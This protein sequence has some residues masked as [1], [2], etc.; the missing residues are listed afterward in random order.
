MEAG[1]KP[2][3]EVLTS[4]RRFLIPEYQRP[5]I[6][7]KEEVEQLWHDL[8]GAF[9][10]VADN[11][12]LLT[13]SEAYFLGPIVVANERDASGAKLSNVVDGQ[14]RLTTLNALLWVIHNCLKAGDAEGT[15]EKAVELERV[16]TL[17]DGRSVLSVAGADQSNFHAIREGTVLD[18]TRELGVTGRLLRDVVHN[19]HPN[20]LIQFTNYVLNM[21]RFVLVQTDSYAD[22]WYLF[23]GLNGKGGPLNPADLIKAYVCGTAQD[24]QAMADIWDSKILPLGNDATSAILDVTRVAN[25]PSTILASR[26]LVGDHANWRRPN[27]SCRTCSTRLPDVAMINWVS[28]RST[29]KCFPFGDQEFPRWGNWIDPGSLEV[30]SID[31]TFHSQVG[32][33]PRGKVMSAWVP[34]AASEILGR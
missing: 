11:G 12:E 5:Y 3:A 28:S 26:L 14:Q 16:L 22:A 10:D 32:P 6:W 15:N 20:D 30:T 17:A 18:E 19:M 4:A 9:E 27:W 13:D 24:G 34:L 7:T 21:S 2:L 29:T 31:R 8:Q 25:L 23:R 1:L 33:Q